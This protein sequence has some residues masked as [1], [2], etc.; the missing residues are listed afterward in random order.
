MTNYLLLGVSILLAVTGQLLMKKGMMV[1]G[2]FPASQMLQHILPMFLSPFVFFGF[3]CFAASSLFWLV[4]LSRLELSFVYPMVS[5]AY[6]IVA[7][8]SFIFFKE[9]VTLMRWMGISVIILG[10]FL[11]SRS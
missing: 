3:A 6:V 8:A 7:L 11:I 2:S 4:V 5:V 1:V 9:N 10:V